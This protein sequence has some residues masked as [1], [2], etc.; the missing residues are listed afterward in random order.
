MWL[1][2]LE[3]LIR[4]YTGDELLPLIESLDLRLL[5]WTWDTGW[6][7]LAQPGAVMQALVGLALAPLVLVVGTRGPEDTD[8]DV[9]LTRRLVLLGPFWPLLVLY[10]RVASGLGQTTF[11]TP[12]LPAG[13]RPPWPGPPLPSGVRRTLVLPA[14]LLGTALFRDVSRTVIRDGAP[15]APTLTAIHVVLSVLPFVVLVAGARIAAGAAMDWRAWVSRF[16]LFY[17]AWWAGALVQ[18]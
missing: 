10:A 9:A 2:G 16:A 1:G 7:W 13:R 12:S 14:A 11:R 15:T 17:A 6:A 3:S 8:R 5:E 18:W 4:W